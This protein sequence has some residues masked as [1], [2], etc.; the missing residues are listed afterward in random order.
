[1]APQAEGGRDQSDEASAA[2]ET[3]D[4]RIVLIG[5]LVMFA[6]FALFIGVIVAMSGG[7]LLD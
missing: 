3:S 4:D 7:R 5:L 2:K 1:L 6:C